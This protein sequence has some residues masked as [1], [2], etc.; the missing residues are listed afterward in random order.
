MNIDDIFKEIIL[1]SHMWNWAPDWA[2]LE[3]IYQ[4]HPNS[5]SILT[6]FAYTYLEELVRTMTSQ[7]GRQIFDDNQKEI[8]NREVGV[9]LIKL[10]IKENSKNLALV[11]VLTETK[12]FFINSKPDDEGGNRNSVVHGYMHP[13]YWNKESFESLLAHIAKLSKYSKF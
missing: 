4:N 12:K 13:R 2:L 11:E 10:A 6:P 8:K 7:Y 9:K 5:Y 1:N 3:E